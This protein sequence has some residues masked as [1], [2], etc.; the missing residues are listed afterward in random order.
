MAVLLAATVTGLASDPTEELQ[1][2]INKGDVR[3]DFE[4]ERGYLRSLLN[5]LKVPVSS[6]TLVFSK[7]SLQSDRITPSTPR[8]LYFN[9]DVYVGWAQGAGFL[10]VMSIDP[11]FGAVFYLLG[12]RREDRPA[13]ERST[14]HE[15]SI[16]HYYRESA[17]FVPRLV[18]TSVIPGATG[19]VE[20]A[21]PIP[22]TDKSPFGE[23]WGGWYVTGTHGDQKHLG[24][25]VLRTPASAFDNIPAA[26]RALSS[27]VTDL[28]RR[29]DTSRYLT[30]HSDIVALMVL[31][32]QVETHNLM[33]LALAKAGGPPQEA[34][35][36]L[37]KGLLFA[38]AA[39]LAAPVQ[40]TSTFA[41]EFAARGPRDSKGRS[42]RDFDLKTRLF[43]YPLSYLIYTE[44][45]DELPQRMK[46]YVYRRL[47]EVL[48]GQ[49]KSPD[50]AHLSA[51]DRAA[52]LEILRETKPDFAR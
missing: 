45:F 12:Q 7:T 19:D 8:A 50:F 9:D 36:P 2:R 37:V 11:E 42:L 43:R 52:I 40:G 15:C 10:E 28:G 14:G 24:N 4:P 18:M 13:F 5:H 6:Q 17:K 27:N 16:C 51:P 49:D 23:R 34:G 3:L 33:A 32:H 41:A 22:T 46:A 20:G 1:Q 30:P 47:R 48:G 35:E 39:P 29:F 21:F 38:G 44:P 25:I 26:A 31:G